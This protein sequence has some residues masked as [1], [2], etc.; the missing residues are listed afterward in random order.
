[1]RHR[2]R[3]V[4]WKGQAFRFE[5]LESRQPASGSTWAVSRRGEFIGTMTCATEVTTK[6]FDL[7]C[8]QWLADLFE[9]KA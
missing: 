7:R 1:M 6:E 8:N 3:L 5:R 9:A 4:G 2:M